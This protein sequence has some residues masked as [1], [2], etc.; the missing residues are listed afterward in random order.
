MSSLILSE[1]SVCP[2]I[3]WW[4]S[5]P[6]PYKF[7]L[8]LKGMVGLAWVLRKPCLV[9]HVFFVL[10]LSFAL[11]CTTVH[12]TTMPSSVSFSRW[13][14]ILHVMRLDSC[15]S[16]LIGRI[17]ACSRRRI[18]SGIG[19]SLLRVDACFLPPPMAGWDACS[20]R[21]GLPWFYYRLTWIF[22]SSICTS[23][24]QALSLPLCLT[25]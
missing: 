10:L 4:K 3:P 6:D 13:Y 8:S 19:A 14:C 17:Y 22:R 5:C 20:T 18:E 1:S 2:S 7:K 11:V 21:G 9:D 25:R 12:T 15:H 23:P 16:P 24:G